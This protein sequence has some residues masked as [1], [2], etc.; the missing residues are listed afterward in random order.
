MVLVLLVLEFVVCVSSSIFHKSITSVFFKISTLGLI[1]GYKTRIK[2]VVAISFSSSQRAEEIL[3]KI[4]NNI[5][6]T[7]TGLISVLQGFQ[8]C[9]E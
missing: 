5:K 8:K 2:E 9:I 3:N 1:P 4:S 6:K 7:Y